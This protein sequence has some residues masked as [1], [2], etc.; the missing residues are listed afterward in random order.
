MSYNCGIYNHSPDWYLDRT[1]SEKIPPS[2]W[3]KL[4]ADMNFFGADIDPK[5]VAT[6]K[7]GVYKER[8]DKVLAGDGNDTQFAAIQE[9]L[10]KESK[11]GFAPK[12][13]YSQEPFLSITRIMNENDLTTTD[14]KEFL[15]WSANDANLKK[16]REAKAKE[17]E[18]HQTH[19]KKMLGL[20][21]Q[22]ATPGS[23]FEA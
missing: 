3:K 9:I 8:W 16:A 13:R 7:I 11:E 17:I 15:K 18:K 19:L 10:E 21:T 22:G 12:T 20:D 2:R 1:K 23:F 14:V 4:K 6:E 5:H